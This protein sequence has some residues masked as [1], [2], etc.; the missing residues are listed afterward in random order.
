MNVVLCSK[1]LRP[2]CVLALH[3]N[4]VETALRRAFLYVGISDMEPLQKLEMVSSPTYAVETARF[5]FHEFRLPSARLVFV[6]I[7]SDLVAKKLADADEE[8]DWNRKKIAFALD[9][10]AARGIV[11][12]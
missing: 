6:T 12:H 1:D 11:G 5:E 8:H 10:E 3:Q 9:S 4:T 7:D 2:I